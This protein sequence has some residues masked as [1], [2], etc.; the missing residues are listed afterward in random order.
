[1]TKNKKIAV[2]CNYA[3]NP[4]RIG[5]MDRFYVGY[6]KKAKELGYEVEWYFLDYE[7]FYFY[8]RLTIFSANNQNV[9]SFFLKKVNQENLRYDILVTHFLAL[10][11]SFFKKAKGEGI[12]QTIVVD[13]NP[14]PLEGFPL[15]KI[16]KNKAKG[17]LYS[18]YIDQFIGV[19]EYTR[20]HILKDYGF[21]LDKKTT[22]VYNGIDTS[23][24]VKRIRENKN[25]FILTSHLRE[26]KG[27]QDLLKALSLLESNITNQMQIDVF[28]EGPY[29][30]ELRRLTNKFNLAGIVNY[31]GSSSN[32]N[33]L[34][35]EYAFLIQPSHGETFCYSIIESL[36]CKVPVVTTLEAGNVLSVI[37]ENTNGFLFNA[38]NYQQLA[39][40][41]KNI[42]LG[43]LKIDKDFSLQIEKDFNLEKMVNEHIQLLCK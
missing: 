6:D 11:T 30:G 9:E 35:S 28:G 43:D 5:G 24:F 40:I 36:V 23:V 15:S 2:V 41:L 33:K 29:E 14:R 21:F 31:E 18:R 42:V 32:L 25:K 7:P 27:I 19:S 22:V 17:I 16:L 4:N 37:E 1:M 12:Q 20:K 26:S 38:G 3:L 10:C 39:T 13:H 8:S 34:Y